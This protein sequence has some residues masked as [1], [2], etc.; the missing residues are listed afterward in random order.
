[1]SLRS[2]LAA[3]VAVVMTLGTASAGQRTS[4]D[5]PRG[6]QTEAQLI[7][8]IQRQVLEYPHYTVYDSVKMRINGG[9]VTLLGMVTMP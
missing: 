9:A 8:N 6:D 7:R 3:A 5:V 1:M 2:T 4:A